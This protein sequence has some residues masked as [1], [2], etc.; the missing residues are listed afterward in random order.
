MPDIQ[1]LPVSVG[2][3][4]MEPGLTID[5]QANVAGQT[6]LT[7]NYQDK[8]MDIVMDDA[9]AER[10]EFLLTKARL[11]AVEMANELDEAMLD[12]VQKSLG[13]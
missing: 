11:K 2:T 9:M 13:L 3:M 6:I 7:F 8:T 4:S 1:V 10:F 5:F 12:Q